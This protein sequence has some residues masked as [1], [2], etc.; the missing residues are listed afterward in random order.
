MKIFDLTGKVAVVTGGTNGL[1]G[2]IW[3]ET[4]EQSGA[5]CVSLDLPEFDVTTGDI[6]KACTWLD[7]ID[8]LVNNAA[9]DNPP[10]SGATFF[11][12]FKRIL[13][14][15]LVGAVRM[16]EQVI[17]SMIR[18]KGGVIVNI[19][20]IQGSVGADHR[21]Y[22]DGFE[23]PV[24]YNLS[25]AALVQLSRSICTQYGRHGIRS[26]TI[27]FGGYGG[28][29]LDPVF[30]EKYLRCVPL[31]RTISKES[32]QAAMLFACCCPEATGQ[33][34]MIDGGFTAW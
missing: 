6:K 16:C 14:V 13:D 25:K 8:I 1:L 24:G 2:P 17:P 9:I 27:A 34:F 26:V 5:K 11:G 21:N 31:G 29:K 20:S 23:K 22:A 10:D 28:G 4:L 19:G 32:L 12:N 7:R 33:Q 3:M 15:N 18:D 30:L